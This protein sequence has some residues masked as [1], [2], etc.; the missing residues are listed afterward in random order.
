[1]GKKALT[2]LREY[3]LS[4]GKP[5][6]ISLYKKLKS[7]RR[8][9]SESIT[10]YMIRTENISNVLKEAGEVISDGLLIAKVLNELPLNFKPF[11]TVITQKKKTL[12]FSEFKVS[13]RSYE[14]TECMCYSPEESNNILQMKTIFKKNNPR[15][16]PRVSKYSHYDYKSTNHNYNNYQKP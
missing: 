8:L 13:L 5:K 16:K 14:E 6:V 4:K 9:E 7:L 10:D 3:Y 12:T 2:I 11:T 1:M 15:N